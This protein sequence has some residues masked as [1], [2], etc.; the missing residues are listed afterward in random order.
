MARQ[1]FVC[2]RTADT[3]RAWIR[4]Y[5]SISYVT[6]DQLARAEARNETW[7]TPRCMSNAE[8]LR[9]ARRAPSGDDVAR[10]IKLALN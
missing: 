5:G 8:M 7:S 4:E 6:A 9:F 3:R 1:V 2:D 10:A